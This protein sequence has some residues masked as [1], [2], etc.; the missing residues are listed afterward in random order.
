MRSTLAAGLR[1]LQEYDALIEA[2]RVALA[3]SLHD[4]F[5]AG[6]LIVGL[7]AVLVLFLKE[8]P[9]K[10]TYGSA[11]AKPATPDGIGRDLG[12]DAVGAQAN[13]IVQVKRSDTFFGVTG[14]RT[15]GCPWGSKGARPGWRSPAGPV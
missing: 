3:G 1:G 14:R 7:G 5:L 13:E 15:G 8:I 6:T 9:L 4:V 12:R 2:I 11:A 10:R